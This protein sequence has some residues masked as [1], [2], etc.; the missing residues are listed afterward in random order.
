MFRRH[1]SP[2]VLLSAVPLAANQMKTPEQPNT[3]TLLRPQELPIYSSIFGK[4]DKY[5]THI[6]LMIFES[7]YTHLFSFSFKSHVKVYRHQ[8]T[9]LQLFD[10]QLKKA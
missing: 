10:H 1:L 3:Q 6:P 5:E 9:N 7:Y 4:Q 2:Y 8:Q